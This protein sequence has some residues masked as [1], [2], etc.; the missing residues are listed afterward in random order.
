MQLKWLGCMLL[1]GFVVV[2][3]VCDARR[4]RE[5]ERRLS[6]WL[7]VLTY[8]RGQISCFGT[9]LGRILAGI[10]AQTLALIAPAA[11]PQGKDLAFICRVAVDTLP[12][13]SGQLLRALSEEIGTIWRREQLKRLDYYI[14]ML[15]KQKEAFCTALPSRLRLKSTLSLCGALALVLLVW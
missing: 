3:C 9:P 5:T 7:Y 2:Y 6:A 12:D 8:A 13:E 4:L 1:V 15:E 14:A 11:E 10:D